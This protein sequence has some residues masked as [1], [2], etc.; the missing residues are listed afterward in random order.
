MRTT[1]ARARKAALTR[2]ER[3]THTPGPSRAR[4]RAS[5]SHAGLGPRCAGAT[6]C[7]GRGRSAPP[8]H[9]HAG[10]EPSAPSG[11]GGRAAQGQGAGWAKPLRVGAPRPRREHAEAA[12]AGLRR[13]GESAPWP[14]CALAGAAPR[15]RRG[16]GDTPGWGGTPGPRPCWIGTNR[17]AGR[18]GVGCAVRGEG[19]GRAGA[20]R[21]AGAE[22]AESGPPWPGE[23]GKRERVT[24]G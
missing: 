17:R 14:G 21:D 6:P 1:R 11:A 18:G 16:G 15:P 23:R 19:E 12:R 8:R 9:G 4:G 20:G 10:A 2:R 13:E 24:S 7:K 5:R 22:R 3:A